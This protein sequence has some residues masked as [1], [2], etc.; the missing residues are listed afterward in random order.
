MKITIIT[1]VRNNVYTITD[2]IESVLRQKDVD[3]E[4]IVIDGNSTDGTL[5]TL[6]PYRNQLAHLVSEPDQG[7]Y[8]AMNK[9]LRLATGEVIGFLNSDDLYQD[10]QVLARIAATF[11]QHPDAQVVYGNLVYVDA[12]DTGRVIRYWRSGPY[13]DGFFEAG[14][15]PPH[16]A[17]FARRSVYQQFGRFNATFHLAA[18]YEIMLRLLRVNGVQSAFLDQV[19]VRMRLGGATNRYWKNIVRGNLE[20]ARAWKVNGLRVPWRLL[21][22]RLVRKI[23]Q[24]VNR[25]GADD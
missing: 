19:L 15:V 25:P 9:G 7:I 23:S 3:L 14:H 1:V 20:I 4:Y 11:R 8:P 6:E 22:N 18:D 16:P 24:F 13:R 2:A 12:A 17:F 5:E 21:P 10:N